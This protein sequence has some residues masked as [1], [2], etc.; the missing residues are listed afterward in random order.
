MKRLLS[1]MAAA[2]LAAACNP[3]QD[4][5]K[6]RDEVMKFHDV[7]MEDHG[8][9]VNNQMKL[10]SMLKDMKGL[11][12]SQP[13]LDTATART[14]MEKLK[15]SLAAAEDRMNDWMHQFEPDVTGK[16]NEDAINY[17]K[18]EKVK[19]RQIDSLYKQEIK[20]SDAYLN[21]FKKS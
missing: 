16:S 18:A 4:Y 1:I 10:D 2:V 3:K 11:K 14:E 19:I 17:F 20:T 21:K 5:K 15:T 7:V 9:V 13:S 8:I 12:T 6:E